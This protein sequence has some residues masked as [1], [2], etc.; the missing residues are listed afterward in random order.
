M[1]SSPARNAHI[2][3]GLDPGFASLGFAVLKLEATGPEVATLGVLRTKKSD[4][5]MRVLA[6]DDNIRRSREIIRP[7]DNLFVAG[8]TD[9]VHRTYG[10]LFENRSQTTM[11][12]AEKMSFPR[13]ASAAAKMAMS[14]GMIV[15]L[16]ERYQLPLLQAS[17]QDVKRRVTGKATATKDDVE[18]A[19]CKRFGRGLRRMVSALPKG[20]HEHAFDALASAVACLDSEEGRAMLRF[21]R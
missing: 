5:K 18:K 6:A 9:Y 12:C 7:L 15:A 4:K 14:W 17:P 20:E 11:V 16:L 1:S 8:N 21:A 10:G 2:I 19:L 13:N 3:L